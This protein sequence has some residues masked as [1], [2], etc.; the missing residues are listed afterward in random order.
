MADH[1]D[2]PE[3]QQQDSLEGFLTN[4]PVSWYVYRV[5]QDRAAATR[6]KLIQGATELIRKK[7]YVATT[8]DHICQHSGVTKGAFFHHFKT[9]EEI[10]RASCRERVYKAV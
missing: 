1:D 7:G 3:G 8:I 6:Q 4:I 5:V 2:S 10:G 9:K